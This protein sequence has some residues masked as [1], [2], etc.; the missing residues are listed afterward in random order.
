M[1]G[2]NVQCHVQIKQC[3]ATDGGRNV[4]CVGRCKSSRSKTATTPYSS[5]LVLFPAT[6]YQLR[7]L[8]TPHSAI[9]YDRP[10]NSAMQFRYLPT[11][12][13]LN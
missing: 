2:R 8:P 12:S 10:M 7:Y 3:R 9:R 13:V 5:P 11:I 1:G 6:S 4:T